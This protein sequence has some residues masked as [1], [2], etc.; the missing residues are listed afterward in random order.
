[1]LLDRIEIDSHGPL[2]R[3]EIGPL[4]HHLNVVL[5][6]AGSGKT[7][8]SRFIR[9]SLIDRDYP[10][11]MLSNSSGRIVWVDSNGWIHCRREQDGTPN[12][13]RTVEF[14]NRSESS[15]AW[16]GYADGW[17]DSAEVASQ[18]ASHY[19]SS[20]ASR[21]LQSIRIPESIVDGVMVDTTVS[22]VSRVVASC[23]SAGLDRDDLARMPFENETARYADSQ[24]FVRTHEDD[25]RRR[26]L[27]AEL[28][29][30]EAELAKLRDARPVVDRVDTSDLQRQRVDLLRRRNECVA[31]RERLF[32]DPMVHEIRRSDSD[33]RLRELHFQA[34]SLR[35]R[36][37][38]LQRWIAELD[39]SAY[40]SS[41][42]RYAVGSG[43]LYALP[44]AWQSTS[45]DTL[46]EQISRAD[47]EIVSLRRVLAD[48]RGIR[49]LLA[50]SH[51]PFDLNTGSNT[52]YAAAQAGR[53]LDPE[54]MQTR[55]YDHFVRAMDHYRSDRPW[56]DFYHAAYQP[57]HPIDDLA[58]RI[59]AAQ[60]HLDWLLSRVGV[61]A[62]NAASD[63][64]S[65][66]DLSW[67]EPHERRTVML[68]T[69]RRVRDQIRHREFLTT[70]HLDRVADDLN[71][72][73]DRL[74]ATR[75]RI[76]E[77]L[78]RTHADWG[79]S[80]DSGSGYDPDWV[81]ERRSAS[82]ELLRVEGELRSVLDESAK[83]RRFDRVLPIVDPIYPVGLDRASGSVEMIDA[84]IAR[85]D[86]RLRELE[87]A[88]AE[89]SAFGSAAYVDGCSCRFERADVLGRRRD[90]LIA[91]LDRDRP[92]ARRESSLSELASRWL[93]RLS[94]G[95]HRIVQWSSVPVAT[96]RCTH[97]PLRG[98]SSVDG[99]ND[100]VDHRVDHRVSVTIDCLDE[101]SV[102]AATRALACLAVRMAAGELLGRMGHAIPL[103]LETHREL[104]VASSN[105]ATEYQHDAYRPWTR[106]GVTGDAIASALSD[107]TAAGRQVLV[108]TEFAP[109]AH[110]LKRSGARSF[111]LHTQRI[112]HPHRP[113]WRG[114]QRQDH[115]AGPHGID[116][117]GR[118]VASPID[119]RDTEIDH[120]V[121]R[122]FD[123]AWIE[124]AGLRE[125]DYHRQVATD[126]PA[127]GATYRDGYYYAQQSSTRP[128]SGQSVRQQDATVDAHDPVSNSLV[129]DSLIARHGK[130]Q[131]SSGVIGD[132]DV[133][134]FM[135]VDSPIDTAPSI[136]AVAA[137]R[138]RRV[139]ISH[140][141]HL[142]NQDSN[143]LADT[144][145]LAGV[146]AKTIRRWQSEC[147]LMC[148]VPQLRGFD[149][150]VLVGCGVQD[151]AQLAAIHPTELL[152]RVK[153]FLATERG[154]QILLSGTSYELSRITSWIASANHSVHTVRRTRTVD[155]RPVETRVT[156]DR[157][158]NDREQQ[159]RSRRPVA[160]EVY[161]TDDD[162]DQERYE[163]EV[164][165]RADRIA[166]EIDELTRD[167]D[168][169]ASSKRTVSA[170]KP[171]SASESRTRR[172]ARSSDR[173]RSSSKGERQSNGEHRSN[174]GQRFYK[175]QDTGRR[176]QAARSRDTR[177]SES[178]PTV[179]GL[180]FYL[181]RADDVV[182]A[183]SI[184]P[185]MAER[186]NRIGI[187]TVNDLLTSDAAAVAEKLKHR[188][189]DRA[190]VTQWQ[191][192]ATL[193]CRV[194][195]LRGHDAQFLVAVGVTTPEE[196]AASNAAALF[197]KVDRVA[198]SSEGKQIVR[199]G[200][201]PDL[202]EV[203]EWIGYA[204]QNRE[205]NAA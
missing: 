109:L 179:N 5:G 41:E 178:R 84:E 194:P 61:A 28:A 45:V 163:V 9:D 44:E 128:F 146:D 161:L 144:L 183:P 90:A 48:I 187:V 80:F 70:Y 186:L 56:A 119:L 37:A 197:A 107:Y 86:A 12:G 52:G 149:A 114:V 94:G 125:G 141:T 79:R 111:E 75:S 152:D 101:Q 69:V 89:Q 65:W 106:E 77:T 88:I 31:R 200:K 196:L 97:L 181:E 131:L 157:I 40:R 63:A 153:T 166:E 22:S 68:E 96:D 27:R 188:R 15:A 159:T 113:I 13:R 19:R 17:F 95:R 162:F 99:M 195:M 140:I 1:M 150:R 132:S 112:V 199:G 25:R 193:V 121:N 126:A 73:L 148:R 133:P 171:S 100:R 24:S 120:Y 201:L 16:D 29:D 10:L 136:D 39:S 130:S 83:L 176:P 117:N 47:R 191:N 123:Q 36:A 154:Q 11:G 98:G 104:F 158:D 3:V 145:G 139:G 46:R 155:G 23:V 135:T 115:Y 60:R 110:Q 164:E 122:A 53:W 175:T 137:Q 78:A 32:V 33:S 103:V 184:G 105:H 62:P 72:S 8:I 116:A 182:D 50:S 138:L 190:T 6:P 185:R 173:N 34:E 192:Q 58:I 167:Y 174:G 118:P 85:L 102:S 172:N 143:R 205:L 203:S 26:E 129:S 21:T 76:V 198:Q 91:E 169:E 7:A 57:L 67:F 74:L 4:S 170:L 177:T 87:A 64:S 14:E 54:W 142:M 20:L 49:N 82:S 147:R 51:L 124:S 18:T 108:L 66:L 202:D 168:R 2:N 71:Q 43:G 35:T 92:I 59:E 160:E 151:P 189:I 55:R 180:R 127:P 204:N 134:Y 42:S 81:A 165:R 38:S 156:R 93:V 30:V